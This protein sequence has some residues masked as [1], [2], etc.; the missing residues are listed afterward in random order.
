MSKKNP[1]CSTGLN[2]AQAIIMFVRPCPE[3]IFPVLPGDLQRFNVN[4]EE[5]LTMRTMINNRK[6]IIKPADKGSAVVV[7]D[8]QDYLKE[9]ER[10]LID[11]K[12]L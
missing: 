5:Y 4:N 10:Q 9:T 7:W 11:S 1:G 3:D 6:V 2:S 12:Y 8:R